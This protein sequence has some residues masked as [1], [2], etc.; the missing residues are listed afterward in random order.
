MGISRLISREKGVT[1][2]IRAVAVPRMALPIFL[3]FFGR[4]PNQ[5][6]VIDN[7]Q[8]IKPPMLECERPHAFPIEQFRVS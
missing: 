5:Q 4:Q 8:C 6:L 3:V 7:W 1:E 2:S